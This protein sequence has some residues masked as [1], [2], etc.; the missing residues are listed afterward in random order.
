MACELY[1][2]KVAIEEKDHG[3]KTKICMFKMIKVPL[4][5]WGII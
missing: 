1:V 4:S 2:H 5:S 3:M